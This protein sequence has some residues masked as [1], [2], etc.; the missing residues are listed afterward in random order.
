MRKARSSWKH[1]LVGAGSIVLLVVMSHSS[2]WASEAPGRE[3]TPTIEK[4]ETGGKTI[5]LRWS[6]RGGT[7]QFRFQM[8]SD[9]E[10]KNVLIDEKVNQPSIVIPRPT[11]PLVYYVRASSIDSK[12]TE[13]E[14]SQPQSFEIKPPSP[15]HLEKPEVDKK[16][17]HLRWSSSE[18]TLRYHLQLAGEETFETVLVEEKVDQPRADLER[19]DTAGVYYVRVRGVTADGNEGEFSAIE[20]VEIKERFPSTAL[21]WG[22]GIFATI[23]VILMLVL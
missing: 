17:I 14:F 12:G 23:V 21:G 9:V 2:I 8:A 19:P 11:F 20:K 18:E 13:G 4:P 5:E 6:S 3:P 1:V 7:G 15:P 22:K 10:F 16:G